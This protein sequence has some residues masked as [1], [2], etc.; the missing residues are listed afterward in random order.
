VSLAHAA[1]SRGDR[2]AVVPFSDRMLP[3]FGPVGDK[4]RIFQM[5]SFLDSLGP[6]EGKTDLAAVAER[7]VGRDQRRGQAVVV[8][9]LYDAAGFRRGLDVLRRAGYVPRVVRVFDPREA[10]PD[11]LGDWELFDVETGA[12]W[13]VTVTEQHLKRYRRQYEQFRASLDRYCTTYAIRQAEIPC[14]APVD[15]LLGRAVGVKR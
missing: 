13:Q 7:F 11:A 9:D 10:A 14:N 5:T 6:P 2:V 12:T 1:L 4:G 3:G 8:S 15:E